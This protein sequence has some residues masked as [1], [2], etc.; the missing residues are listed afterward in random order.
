MTNSMINIGNFS[1][2]HFVKQKEFKN[3]LSK[4]V[5]CYEIMCSDC[6]K[7]GKTLPNNENSLR[8][9]LHYEY[10]NIKQVRA[11][12]NLT[13]YLFVPEV[14]EDRKKNDI[15]GRTDLRVIIK[16]RTFENPQEYFTIECKRIDGNKSL[17]EAYI[18]NGI[19]RFVNESPL[20][21]SYYRTNG[22]LGFIVKDINVAN[23]M[24]EIDSLLSNKYEEVKVIDNIVSED[25]VP[26]CYM[27][28]Y[29]SQNKPL[30]LYHLMLD[31]SRFV[32]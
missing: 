25:S 8:D 31:V 5:M 1:R 16:S 10:L 7:Q 22:M 26:C 30:R 18:V 20:Y 9:I 24:N 28:T 21:L 32:K 17:N 27:S 13:Q 4:V 14:P 2:I 15:R 19:L 12:C 11:K 6:V 3:I 23:N 29:I